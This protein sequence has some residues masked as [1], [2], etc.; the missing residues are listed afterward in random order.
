[1]IFSRGDLQ[2]A[3]VGRAVRVTSDSLERYQDFCVEHGI[4]PTSAA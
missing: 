3:R 4:K 2:T 1:M